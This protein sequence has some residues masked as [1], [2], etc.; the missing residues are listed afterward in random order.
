MPVRVGSESAEASCTPDK[1]E[2]QTN[3]GE[4]RTF[5]VG[6]ENRVDVDRGASFYRVCFGPERNESG[7]K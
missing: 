3:E 4:I 5:M 2:R 6:K 7:P 1:R